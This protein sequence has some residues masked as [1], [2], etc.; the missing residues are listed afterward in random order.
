MGLVRLN[1]VA[2]E[3][4]I[5]VDRRPYLLAP[6]RPAEGEPRQLREGE[7][8]TELTPAWQE[9]AREAG[10]VMVRPQIAPRTNLAHEVTVYAKERGRDG[11]FHHAAAKA[12]WEQGV[13]LGDKA[14]LKE[15][16]ESVSLDWSE[17]EPLLDA[18]HYRQRVLDEHQAAKDRGVGGTPT[19]SVEGGEVD[20][21]DKSV[22]DMRGMFGK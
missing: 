22:D 8:Q 3:S 19:Y 4:P 10:I 17:L 12:Y 18:G 7:T 15:I 1:K 21:G 13:N 2:G 5:N 20:F 14:V 16:A 9:R 6:D 11:E